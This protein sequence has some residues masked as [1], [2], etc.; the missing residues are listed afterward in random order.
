VTERQ[1]ADYR[2]A[3][4]ACLEGRDYTVR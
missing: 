4:T 3:F 2:R 1:A